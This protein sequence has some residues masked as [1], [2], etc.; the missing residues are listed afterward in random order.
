MLY[1]GCSRC[2]QILLLLCVYARMLCSYKYTLRA[3]ATL[4]PGASL[5]STVC[6]ILHHAMFEILS[7]FC[8]FRA[9]VLHSETNNLAGEDEKDENPRGGWT[10]P[11]PWITEK[12]VSYIFR[13]R[14]PT[15]KKKKE[16]CR[17]PRS[18]KKKHPLQRDVKNKF[19]RFF[20]QEKK[21]PKIFRCC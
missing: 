3:E 18:T 16:I 11:Y 21:K 12:L 13:W 20:P 6:E 1:A 9:C 10:T 14:T 8:L 15:E 2:I 19:Q 5:I 4:R 17:A 7:T